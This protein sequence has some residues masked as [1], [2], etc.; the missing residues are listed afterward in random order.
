MTFH[1]AGT[2]LVSSA[3]SESARRDAQAGPPARPGRPAAAPTLLRTGSLVRNPETE[4]SF[5]TVRVILDFGTHTHTHTH[6]HSSCCCGQTPKQA[7][8]LRIAFFKQYTLHEPVRL[9]QPRVTRPRI[10]AR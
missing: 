4:L 7:D 8:A 1:G 5:R 3:V 9:G 10:R 6:T 2:F